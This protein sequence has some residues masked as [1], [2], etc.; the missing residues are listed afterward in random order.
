MFRLIAKMETAV[1]IDT[2]GTPAPDSLIIV[3]PLGHDATTAAVAEKLDA[4]R[5]VAIDTLFPLADATRRTIMTTPATT[6]PN[7]ATPRTRSSPSMAF[8]SP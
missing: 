3:T 6:R 2:G 1:T 4:S 7:S 5:T 8:L